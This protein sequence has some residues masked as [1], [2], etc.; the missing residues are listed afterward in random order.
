MA[1]LYSSPVVTF[2]PS[3]SLTEPQLASFGP[4]KTWLNTLQ[5]SLN[6]QQQI[7]QHAFHDKPYE[8][9]SIEIQAVDYFGGSRIGFLKLK[10]V[11][12]NGNGETL[13]GSVFLR[14]GSVAMLVILREDVGD[15][16][17]EWVL[18]TVQPRVPAGSLEF[19]EL[20]AGMIDGDTFSGAAAKEIKEECGIEIKAERLVDLTELALG[21]FVDSGEEKVQKAVYPSPGG[22]YFPR[23]K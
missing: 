21:G 15:A 13:P 11:L 23:R 3:V 2:A 20:P 18:L 7:T 19:V 12:L 14:G 6:L 1:T 5:H 4:Y 17:E 9:R 22:E 8:L 10:A 16:S